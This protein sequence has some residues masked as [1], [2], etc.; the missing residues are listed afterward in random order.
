MKKILPKKYTKSAGIAAKKISD[1][2]KNIR[3]K[4]NIDTVEE[5]KD[6]ASKKSMQIA[7]K[8][9]S[10]KYKKMRGIKSPLLLFLWMKQM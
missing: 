6:A 10:N 7:A 5:I 2:Y 8:K 1:K 4:R 3:K 9:I